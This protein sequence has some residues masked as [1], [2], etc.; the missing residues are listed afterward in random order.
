MHKVFNM[1]RRI[2]LPIQPAFNRLENMMN[3]HFRMVHP[4][5]KSLKP[6][7]KEKNLAS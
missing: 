7:I 6:E 2:Y 3:K 1:L 4:D 5:A